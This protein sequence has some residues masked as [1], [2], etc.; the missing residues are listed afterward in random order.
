MPQSN[1]NYV[2]EK[3][4][5]PETHQSDQNTFGSQETTDGA[6]SEADGAIFN[7]ILLHEDAE[8]FADAKSIETEYQKELNI[9]EDE[10]RRRKKAYALSRGTPGDAWGESSVH[11]PTE[12][13]KLDLQSDAKI[14]QIPFKPGL[15]PSFDQCNDIK[16][17][18]PI[19][20]ARSMLRRHSHTP[21]EGRAAETSEVLLDPE[22]SYNPWRD[23]RNENFVNVSMVQLNKRVWREEER[24]KQA[25]Q[26][27]RDLYKKLEEKEESFNRGDMEQGITGAS[28]S[29]YPYKND[30]AKPLQSTKKTLHSLDPLT[31]QRLNHVQ[32]MSEENENLVKERGELIEKV[33]R[34]EL[35][36]KQAY[37]RAANDHIRKTAVKLQGVG[38]LRKGM[39]LD[40]PAARFYDVENGCVERWARGKFLCRSMCFLALLIGFGFVFDT[41]E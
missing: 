29:P 13:Q 6:I 24:V 40:D 28:I 33:E 26:E 18:L 39:V 22:P 16:S 8:Q 27:Q 19:F 5:S 7:A 21:H 34:L 36:S 10:Y 1:D 35:E 31:W 17:E 3:V 32:K 14:R 15:K 11:D 38:E 9:S 25:E 37:A 4:A 23:R 41:F 12:L 2:S 20:P 30:V